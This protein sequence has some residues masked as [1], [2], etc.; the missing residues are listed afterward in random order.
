MTRLWPDGSPILV[1][2]ATNAA[3]APLSFVWQ[4]RAH[5]VE[6]ITRHWRVRTDWWRVP[7]WRAYYKLT[8]TS[9]LL[10]IIYH[11]LN[12]GEWFLQRLYD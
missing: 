3:A 1:S 6:M 5:D 4:G 12:S 11:D 2:V 10:V 8:T 9:G 7:A